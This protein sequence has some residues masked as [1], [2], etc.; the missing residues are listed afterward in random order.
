MARHTSLTPEVQA[1][2]IQALEC[3]AYLETAAAYAGI[4]K[5]TFFDWM[6]RGEREIQRREH[7]KDP[8]SSEDV[9][10][11]FKYTINEKLA[12][13]EIDLLSTIK[14]A[15]N[16][17]WRAPAFLLERRFS[18]RYSRRQVTSLSVE[19]GE[20]TTESALIAAIKD[21]AAIKGIFAEDIRNHDQKDAE[22]VSAETAKREKED[23]ERMLGIEED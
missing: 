7:G 11:D 15:G 8:R 6:R 12:S 16:K 18:D 14:D 20:E 4:A 13:Y 9:F 21:P 10:V 3:G 23:E 1:K 17:D 22:K 19:G 2:I 5:C